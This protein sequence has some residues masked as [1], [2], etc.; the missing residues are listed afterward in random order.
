VPYVRRDLRPINDKLKHDP[1]CV[2][3]VSVALA[4]SFARKPAYW[5]DI[6]H[7]LYSAWGKA[8]FVGRQW[9]FQRDNQDI[10]GEVVSHRFGTSGQALGMLQE[11]LAT[12]LSEGWK[13]HEVINGPV[14]VEE[15]TKLVE[16]IHNLAVGLPTSTALV[17]VA[18]TTNKPMTRAERMKEL[19]NKRKVKSPW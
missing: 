11:L 7:S 5:L 18:I 15:E 17:K 9:S 3:V 16:S 2:F 14:T 13:V 4:K 1:N 8:W 19:Q 6:Y 10:T 12:K